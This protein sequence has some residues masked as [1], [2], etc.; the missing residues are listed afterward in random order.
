MSN[1]SHSQQI[2]TCVYEKDFIKPFIQRRY[3]I[4][5]NSEKILYLS[6]NLKIILIGLSILLISYNQFQKK[7]TMEIKPIYKENFIQ[8]DRIKLHYLDWGGSGQPLVLLHAWGDSPYIFEGIA[9]KYLI[10]GH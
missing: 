7:P 3:N 9:P 4:Y 10:L 5:Q 8:T 6:M 2:N 1:V